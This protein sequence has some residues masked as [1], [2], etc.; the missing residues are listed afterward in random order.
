M[1]ASPFDSAIFRGLLHDADLAELFSDIE[2]VRALLIVEGALARAQ[3]RLGMIPRE[4]A[5]FI[6]SA[7]N[8]VRIDPAAL[9]DGTRKSM[10]PVPALVEAFREAAGSPEHSGFIHW[11]ATSQDIW[12][13][14]LAV[15]LRRVAATL[16][17]RI[18]DVV[19]AA[20][21]LAERHAD[22][23]MAG[24]TY[25]QV[26]TPTTFGAVVTN[27]GEPH[28]R[29]LARLDALLPDLLAVSLSGAAGTLSAMDGRGPEVRALMAEDLGLTDPGGTRHARRDG[30][31]AFAGWAAGVAGTLGKMAEDLLLLTQSGIGEVQLGETG[32]SST[33]PQKA[34][35]VGP[36]VI[37]TLARHALS[38]TS[39]LQIAA[40]HRQERDGAAWMTEWMAL[41]GICFS[42]GQ[43]LRMAV[44]LLNSLEP[45]PAAM[46]RG[47]DPEGLGLIHA[48]ALSFTLAARMP[49]PEARNEV[50]SLVGRALAERRKLSDLASESWPDLPL[51]EIFDASRGTGTA[52][53]EA[54]AFA[55]AAHAL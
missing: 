2:V 35:P 11:G 7:A 31:G 8:E 6:S 28:L 4:A 9:S 20:A 30:P 15:R 38:W 27:W 23:P 51:G 24:R 14:G 47:L 12:D 54:R 43:A 41:P 25:G 18:G 52:P 40:V 10:V 22:L 19:G 5:A 48:E 37:L 1:T 32:G 55:E 49:L 39:A 45:V 29:H 3:G 17:E 36:T 13:T 44:D 53:D 46:A 50:E 26:A 16:S 21:A 34:N 42:L 33:M